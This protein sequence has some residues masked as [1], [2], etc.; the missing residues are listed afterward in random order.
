MKKKIKLKS[1]VEDYTPELESYVNQLRIFSQ[2][3]HAIHRDCMLLFPAAR[4]LL[5][6][7]EELKE[8]IKTEVVRLTGLDEAIKNMLQDAHYEEIKKLNEDFRKWL[9]KE[10]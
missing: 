9:K 6:G 5:E 3:L 2:A 4:Y 8:L 7:I 10:G 1:I